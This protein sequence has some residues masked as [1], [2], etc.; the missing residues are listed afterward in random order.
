MVMIEEALRNLV[1]VLV[2]DVKGELPNLLLNFPDF[3]PESLLPW[4]EGAASPS[5]LRP[6]EELDQELASTRQQGHATWDIV[7]T[8]LRQFRSK[9]ALRVITPGASAGELLRMLSGLERPSERWQTDP[10]SASDSLGAAVSLVLRLIGR[11]PDPAKSRE[12][13]LLM[14]FA[15]RRLSNGQSADL[16]ALLE[17]LARPPLEKVGALTVDAFLPKSERKAL[18]AEL[19]SLLASPSFAD[20][21]QGTTLDIGAWMAPVQGRTP[22][23]G[24]AGQGGRRSLS[25][26]QTPASR[27]KRRTV[28]GFIRRI[29]STNAWRGESSGKVM[30]SSRSTSS[31]S[32][33]MTSVGSVGRISPFS[34]PLRWPLDLRPAS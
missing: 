4:V 22:K 5:E 2:I 11:D 34:V 29:R 30:T 28:P 25:H 8:R 3:S 1:P 10:E 16:G 31:R 15:E 20:W 24:S 7:E 26:H 18:A 19:N 9:T 32:A 23:G 17:E 13:V 27:I 33:S 14:V 6:P 21:R 12:H